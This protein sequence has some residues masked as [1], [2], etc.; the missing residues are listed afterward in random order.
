ML[1]A[2]GSDSIDIG[3]V[4][5]A[6]PVFA[7]A[8][9]SKITIVGARR[10]PAAPRPSSCRRALPI[11]SIA[12]AQ[13]ARR[14][15]SPEGSSA[16]YHLLAVLP[17]AG[18]TPKDVTVDYLQPADALAAFTSGHVDAW[19]T[20]SPFI[21]EATAQDGGRVLVNGKQ[22]ARTYSFQVA[23]DA[24]LADPAKAA[25]INDYIKLVNQA[26]AWSSTHTSDWATIWAKATGLPS[27]T[28]DEGGQA[29]T[30]NTPVAIDA[31]RDQRRAEA[32]TDAF[33]KS[34]SLIPTRS[35]DFMTN[36]ST[37][38]CPARQRAHPLVE[39]SS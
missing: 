26:H 7:A 10:Q 2:M 20:W 9:G 6:P 8:G 27:A 23:S 36:I 32:S 35:P 1:Q 22:S 4:G 34:A 14:S 13:A 17:A 15:P 21:E 3:G 39:V 12:A 31:D 25:A 37:T 33:Y 28:H 29:T 38:P 19:D 30:L 11:K 24:A 5:D 18:L 16:D